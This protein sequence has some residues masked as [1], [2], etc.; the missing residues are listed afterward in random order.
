MYKRQDKYRGQ[1]YGKIYSAVPLTQEQVAEFE[2]QTGKLLREKIQLKNKVD[3]N[4]LGGVK[5]LIDGK[6]I[7]AS[8]RSGLN[9]LRQ[10]LYKI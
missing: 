10:N 6:M 4:L 1:A 9:E 7:D 8:L 5:I 3:K 2:E